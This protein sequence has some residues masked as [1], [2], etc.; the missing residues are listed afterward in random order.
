MN[1]LE[2]AIDIKV[3][4]MLPSV[5]DIIQV[6][7]IF[8]AEGV[9]MTETSIFKVLSYAGVSERQMIPS[10]G[11][12]LLEVSKETIAGEAYIGRPTTHAAWVKEELYKRLPQIS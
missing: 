3:D 10:F 6:S 9:L 11:R 7:N 2:Y 4:G 12:Y 5:G 8:W 1:E